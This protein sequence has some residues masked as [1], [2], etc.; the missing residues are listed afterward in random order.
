MEDL[1]P[2][3]DVPPPS[4]LP[5]SFQLALGSNSAHARLNLAIVGGGFLVAANRNLRYMGYLDEAWLKTIINAAAFL[6]TVVGDAP[7]L[8]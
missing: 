1:P 6:R 4:A 2:G 8:R 5:G 7:G 3:I